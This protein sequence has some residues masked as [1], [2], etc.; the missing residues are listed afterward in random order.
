MKK[1]WIEQIIAIEWEMFQKTQN[2]GGRAWC[3][4]DYKQFDGNRRAQFV[5][6]DEKTLRLYLQDLKEAEK[7]GRNLVTL[8]YAYMMETTS[9]AEYEQLKARLPEVDAEKRQLIER[10]AEMTACWCEE[11][12]VQYPD[13]ARR[14]RPPR[15]EADAPGITSAQTYCRGELSTYSLETLRSLQEVYEQ[16][17]KE[18]TNLFEKTVDNEMRFILGKGLNGNA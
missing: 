6:W 1:E 15:T 10:M 16:Y 4:D 18:Q 14:G 12:A 11:F 2:V 8:K 3:Q 9:P 13:V 5:N 7:A 17:E